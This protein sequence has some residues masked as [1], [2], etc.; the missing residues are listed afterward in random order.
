MARMQTLFVLMASALAVGSVSAQPAASG[1]DQVRPVLIASD[2]NG[3]G[4]GAAS[5]DGRFL[6]ASSTRARGESAIWLFDR[7]KGVWRPLT[8]PGNG[9]R[10][11][12]ISPDG[13]FVVFI[14]DRGG[15]T[16]VWA[17]VVETGREWA[18][19]RDITE[20]EYPAWS[21]DGRQLVFTGGAWKARN[22][23]TLPFSERS[24]RKSLRPHPVLKQT[25]HVGACNF[26]I[27][28]KLV[29][30]VYSGNSGDLIE[31]DPLT[32]K[33]HRLTTGGWWFYKPD[34]APDGSIAVTVI[35][36]DGE[37]IRF[38]PPGGRG[39][40]LATPVLEG[41]WP[42]FTRSGNELVYHRTVSEGV[43]LKLLDLQSGSVSPLEIAGKLAAFAA[44]SPDGRTLAYCRSDGDRWSVRLHRLDDGKDWALPLTEESCNPAWSP[45]GARLAISL[46]KDGHWSQAVVGANG[47][48]LKILHS[49]SSTEW[50]LDAP[51]AWSPDGTRLAFALN[52]AP[53]E[54]DLFIAEVGSGM[55]RNITN[56]SWYDE[57]PSWSADGQSVVFMST[58]G[59]NWTWG[60]FA[61]PAGGGQARIL[62][63]PDAIERRFPQ[64]DADGTVWWIE[65]DLCLGSTYLVRRGPD[66]KARKFFDLPG[67]A[68]MNRSSAGRFAIVPISR[69]RVEYWSL[70]LERGGL[71]ALP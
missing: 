43:G 4:D 47:S 51:A 19:T 68:S 63:E 38:M 65:S 55:V 6:V 53:Y 52:T 44:I 10:E 3:A 49:A 40:P 54:S 58:R 15:Q 22:F 57:G 30:H 61:I 31:I 35:G 56:D 67:A 21:K 33:Q 13:R 59:G 12:A 71:T 2:D 32:G 41:S 8:K 1:T 23:F 37:T 17:V 24:G 5:A 26:K 66:G 69:R 27:D 36:D 9:D 20:E 42:Q 34:A 28:G 16:D 70:T 50:R 11:P 7:S 48:A 62:V 64:L 46:R 39:E 14:S 60:L 29:C 25:G 18:L 45:D